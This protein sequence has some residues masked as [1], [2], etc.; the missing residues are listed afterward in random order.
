M[1]IGIATLGMFNYQFP[2]TPTPP[3]PSPIAVSP[4]IGGG[5]GYYTKAKPIVEV[6][7]LDTGKDKKPTIEVFPLNTTII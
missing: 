4:I 5:G 7:L 2:V 6:A 1:S 3:T